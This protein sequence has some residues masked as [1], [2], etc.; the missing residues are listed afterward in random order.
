MSHAHDNSAASPIA[1][2]F[3]EARRSARALATYPGTAPES[4][5]AAYA[6][7]DDA[8]ALWP[9]RIAGWK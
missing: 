3:V 6:I 2:A 4:L 1:R 5:E 8:I 7:Q 9:D